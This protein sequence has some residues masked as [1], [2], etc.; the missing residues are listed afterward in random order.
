MVF[1]VIVTI[2]VFLMLIF[3]FSM[4]F[5]NLPIGDVKLKLNYLNPETPLLAENGSIIQN[6]VR[7]GAV[8]VFAKNLRFNH[9]L[10]SYSIG[11]G[12]DISHRNDMVAA[13]NIFSS[14]VKIVSFYEKL[15]DSD[16]N[17]ECSDEY[18]ELGKDLF[19]AGE[20]GPS[21]IINTSGFKIIEKGKVILYNGGDCDYP[22][23]A[24]HELGHVFGFGHSPD[25]KN[26]MFNVSGCDQRMS[27]DMVD[28]ITELYSIEPLSDAKI[29]SVSGSVMG[30][31]LNFNISV[32]NEGLIGIDNISLTVFSST[33]DNSSEWEV[34][35]NVRLGEIGIGYGRTL[36]L[37]NMKLPR[38]VKRIKF[39]VDADNVVRELDEDNNVV[40][41]RV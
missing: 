9:N 37:E 2:L 7:Y 10:L 8:P 12:C 5:Q 30:N 21:K 26:I 38:N 25:P 34:V 32:L 15:G 41:M 35:D 24:L 13:F 22:I 27:D 6:L 16:I 4:V 40:E 23:V 3:G 33:K 20:G 36:R 11:E 39:A 18:I 28:I 31:Y 17:V 1:K 19:A 29:D 14:E